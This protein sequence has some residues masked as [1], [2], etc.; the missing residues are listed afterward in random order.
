MVAIGAGVLVG[1]GVVGWMYVNRDNGS[2]AAA[3]KPGQ[4]AMNNSG[5]GS[6]ESSGDSLRVTTN[7]DQGLVQGQSIEGGGGGAGAG[8]GSGSASGSGSSGLGSGGSGSNQLPTPSQFSVYDQYK[9]NPTAL[10]IDVKPGDGKAVEKGSVVTMQYR[11]WLT[12]GKEFDESYSTGKPFTFTEGAGTVIEGM[13]EAMYGMKADGQRRLIIPPTV[14][15]GAAGK[16]P[17]P[18]DSVMVFDV[19]LVSVQ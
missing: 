11:G 1:A 18:P 7:G 14:G 10:Y 2:E 16:D 9:N 19:E 8:A 3:E 15:Y 6:S 4:V 13:A 12:N 5:N 17:I